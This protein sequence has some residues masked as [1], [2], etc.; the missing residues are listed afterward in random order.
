[1][2]TQT[3]ILLIDDDLMVRQALS[4]ALAVENYHVVPAANRQEGLREFANHLIDIVLLDVN[5]RNENG[6]E[7]AR[8]FTALRPHLLIIGMTA[9]PEQQVSTSSALAVDVLLEKP[10][11]LYALI[12]TLDQ[13]CSQNPEPGRRGFSQPQLAL[14]R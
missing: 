3:S 5:P 1:M 8:R 6:W 10:I 9:R 11:N 12:H 4:Q 13:L 14:Q 7:T 2:N